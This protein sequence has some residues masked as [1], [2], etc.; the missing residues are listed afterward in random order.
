M[1]LLIALWCYKI[2]S[3]IYLHLQVKLF[4]KLKRKRDPVNL[5]ILGRD[6]VFVFF[7]S[8]LEWQQWSSICLE[9]AWNTLRIR[10][11]K[12]GNALAGKTFILYCLP[13]LKI[14]VDQHVLQICRNQCLFQ[15]NI[16]NDSDM[17]ALINLL[18]ENGRKRP[19]IAWVCGEEAWSICHPT[20]Y[21]KRRSTYFVDVY[22]ELLHPV[23]GDPDV[24]TCHFS[25]F[26]LLSILQFILSK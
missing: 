13:E 5:S 16:L 7:Y 9:Y 10:P 26:P 1:N 22:F 19:Y 21:G 8:H 3:S 17:H 12:N 14:E 6:W 4:S 18:M 24:K 20:S 15:R 25:I 23:I 11:T 2:N